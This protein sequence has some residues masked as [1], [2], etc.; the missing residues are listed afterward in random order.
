[1]SALPAVADPNVLVGY[2]TGDDSGVYRLADDLAVVL[3]LD[4][5]TPI[6]DDARTFGQIAAANAFSDVYAMGGEPRAALNFLAVPP[7]EAESDLARDILAG[8]ADKV[9]EAGAA[10]IGGHTIDDSELKYGLCAMGTVH[11]DRILTN[12]AAQPGDGL[13]LTKPLGTGIVSTAVKGGL[14]SDEHAQAA[15]ESM[16]QLNAA[17]AQAARQT[18]A[19][20]CTDV[21]GFGLVGHLVQM[22]QASGAAAVIEASRVPLLP[23]ARHYCAMGLRTAAGGRSREYYGCRVDAS[24]E[25][26]D[27]L[28]D[29]L[30]DAQT[31]GGLL[32]ASPEPEELLARLHET[33]V[34]AAAL[35][36]R[37]EAEPA[38]KLRII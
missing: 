18:H 35:I 14:A 3:T 5:L 12:A 22:L 1:M 31:S 13:V 15:A 38:G 8:G 26:D 20:A 28:L 2:A 6:V 37:T 21:T 33:G 17:A 4:V 11:P 10:L 30:H 34:T 25:I 19:H 32:I 7:E 23:G 24:D 36:G 9:A 16:L 29:L 27:V